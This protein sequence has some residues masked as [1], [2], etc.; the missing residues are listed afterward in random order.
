MSIKQNEIV[1][2][3][4]SS[5]QAMVLELLKEIG[6]EQ[7]LEHSARIGIKPKLYIGQYY[8]NQNI[9]GIGVGS[10]TS[11]FSD[12]IRGCPPKAKDILEYLEKTF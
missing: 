9:R 8:R 3:Y 7:G 12:C 1:V 5:L 2:I 10:C 11:S 4:G 6:P